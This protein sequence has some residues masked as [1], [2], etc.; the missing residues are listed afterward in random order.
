MKNKLHLN[1]MLVHVPCAT[2]P[3]ASVGEV[4]AI[5]RGSLQWKTMVSFLLLVSF[6]SILPSI[7]TGVFER[8]HKHATWFPSFRRKMILS[9]LL[10]LSLGFSILDFG[11]SMIRIISILFVQPFLVIWIMILGFISTQ[12]RFGGRLSYRRDVEHSAGFDILQPTL[13]KIEETGTQIS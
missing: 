8:G 11:P 4:L 2:I 3:L 5:F 9:I 12:G 7:I 10:F 1:S 6:L 13:E